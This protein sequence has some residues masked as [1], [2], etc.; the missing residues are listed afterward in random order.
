MG[1]VSLEPT[2]DDRLDWLQE[3]LRRADTTTP[4]LVADVIAGACVRVAGL[5][6]TTHQALRV[7]ELV[8]AHAW[9][10][11]ALALVELELPHWQ[12]RRLVY[13]AGEWYCQLSSSWEIPAGLD[14]IVEGHHHALSLAI[15][16]S[17]VEAQRSGLI[18]RKAA[19]RTVPN[20][21]RESMHV[22]CCDNFA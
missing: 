20:V 16:I 13:D 2:T 11:A 3:G 14:E 12:L 19:A 21:L 7:D 9:I 8:G 22:V 17:L 18:A 1:I 4:A 15:L 10:D 6:H 5:R